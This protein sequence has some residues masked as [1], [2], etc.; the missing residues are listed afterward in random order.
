ME[1]VEQQ[2]LTWLAGSEK[3]K[4]LAGTATHGTG[5]H[6]LTSDDFMLADALGN[7]EKE[8]KAMTAERKDCKWKVHYHYLISKKMRCFQKT[9]MSY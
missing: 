2:P 1:V 6:H 9:W 5:G 8:Q 4:L 3:A 7:L